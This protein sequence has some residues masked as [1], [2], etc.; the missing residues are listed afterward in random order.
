MILGWGGGGQAGRDCVRDATTLA[1]SCTLGRR[2]LGVGRPQTLDSL[3]GQQGKGMR[4]SHVR[5]SAP[6]FPCDP[7]RAPCSAAVGVRD[8]QVDP[9]SELTVPHTKRPE[10]EFPVHELRHP[11]DWMP[12]LAFRR[13]C[14][15]SCSAAHSGWGISPAH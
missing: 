3:Q 8:L 15:H 6:L 11:S 7:Q 10:V 9:A 14:V 2:E 1:L 5:G 12:L 4:T 13:A